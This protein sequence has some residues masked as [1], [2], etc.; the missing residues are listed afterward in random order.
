VSNGIG[1]ATKEIQN[2]KRVGRV[3]WGIGIWLE[4]SRFEPGVPSHIV[5]REMNTSL[6]WNAS[7]EDLLAFDWVYRDTNLN[8]LQPDLDDLARRIKLL[9]QRNAR[10]EWLDR[11]HY[12]QNPP[13]WVAPSPWVHTTGYCQTFGGANAKIESES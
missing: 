11:F 2:G 7:S 8:A 12:Y 5:L 3:A 1:W 4:L 13:I 10:R 9:E 6:C